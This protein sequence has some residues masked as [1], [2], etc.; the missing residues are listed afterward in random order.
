MRL[1]AIHNGPKRTTS[2][3]GG[4]GLL[5]M[6]LELDNGRCASKDVGLPMG[7]NCEISHWLER[8]TKYSL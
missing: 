8:G 6:V 1:T 7:V 2:A 3:S 5:Q 4:I